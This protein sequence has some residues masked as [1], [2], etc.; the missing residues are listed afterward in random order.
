MVIMTHASKKGWGAVHHSIKTK[1]KWSEQESLQHKNYLELRQLS[2]SKILCQGQISHDH[3]SADRQ[4]NGYCLYQQQRGNTFSHSLNLAVELWECCQANDIFVIA[5]HIPGKDNIRRF[6]NIQ[7]CERLEVESN[8][9]PTLSTELSDWP[10][11]KSP[12]YPAQGLY[13]LEIRPWL[14]PHRCLYN[15][16]VSPKGVHLFTI[17]SNRQTLEKVMTNKAELIL[18]ALVWQAQPWW[19]VLLRL[20]ISRPML[21]P[22]NPTHQI[23][24]GFIQ[25]ILVYTWTFFTSLPVLP[26]WGHSDRCCQ[27]TH[28]SHSFLPTQNLQIKL[29]P[30]GAAGV[31][32]GKFIPFVHL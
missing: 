2:G 28:R 22:N 32:D 21:L 14:H 13:Q 10:V 4:H 23:S 29:Q 1:G 16:L 3:I 18:V 5:T 8:H 20:L 15:K 17:Q 24:R 7:G 25:C 11:C 27:A 12:D 6:E 19:P 30:F 26:S 31:L 9:H